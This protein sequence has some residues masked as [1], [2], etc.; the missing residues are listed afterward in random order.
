M[1]IQEYLTDLPNKWI[2][3]FFAFLGFVSFL[4]LI[5]I[6]TK[7]D[8]QSIVSYLSGIVDIKNILFCSTAFLGITATP[9]IFPC[10][11]LFFLILN[12]QN[13]K[14]M[15]VYL[16]SFFV[17]F[18]ILYHYLAIHYS[19]ITLGTWLLIAYMYM[20]NILIFLPLF[21]LIPLVCFIFEKQHF[22]IKNQY[23]VTNKY[24]RI[25]VYIF[26]FYFTICYIPLMF[27]LSILAFTMLFSLV[28]HFFIA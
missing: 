16:I 22:S 12:T 13:K 25:F 17:L 20:R 7:Q 24:Y 5:A 2:T 10:S 14:H 23:L 26:S 4:F 8:F 9:A 18:F 21:L 1:K 27:S 3:N 28:F 11:V 19:V 15:C 6:S